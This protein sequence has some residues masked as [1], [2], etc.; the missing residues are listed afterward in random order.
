[1]IGRRDLRS[2]NSWMHNSERL[3]KGP[4]RCTL[5]IHPDDAAARG[6]A[7][8]AR[9]KVASPRGA[10]EL[11]VETTDSMMPGVVSVPHGWGHGRPGV[12]LGVAARVPGVSIN[13]VIDPARIDELSGTSALTGQPVE[14]TPA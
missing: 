13:D 14:V 1:M 3:V 7:D 6:L 9:A 2:N 4:A 8:G 5:L 12:K 10:I 11:P